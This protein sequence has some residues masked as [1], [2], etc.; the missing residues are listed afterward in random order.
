MPSPRDYITFNDLGAA[1]MD[2]GNYLKGLIYFC[3]SLRLL[4]ENQTAIGNFNAAVSAIESNYAKEGILYRNI[5]NEFDESPDQKI[6]L[7]ENGCKETCYAAFSFRSLTPE[8]LLPFL[9]SGA[10]NGKES[11]TIKNPSFDPRQ[12]TILLSFNRG[13]SGETINFI[14]PTCGG[15]YYKVQLP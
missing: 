3:Q 2:K 9:I 8:I 11:V 15:K 10:T 7:Q 4:P 13:F 1:Y 12:G 14:F 6:F 5:L